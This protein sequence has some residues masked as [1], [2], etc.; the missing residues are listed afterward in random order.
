MT[1]TAARAI[2]PDAFLRLP[3]QKPALE[4]NPDGTISA[5]MSPNTDHAAL[6]MH[7][8]RL[9]LNHLDAVRQP[10]Y[11]YSELRTNLAG[12]SRLPDVAFY[13]QR[14]RT[15]T[16]KH[17]LVAADLSI[18]ILSPRD[19]VDE[20]RAKCRW[21]LEQGGQFALLV[22]PATPRRC[23]ELFGPDAA[24]GQF[25]DATRLPLEQLLPGLN[26]TPDA[27]FAILDTP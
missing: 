3:E 4:L 27:I 11:V 14:P 21:Y 17:A 25:Y 15:S 24:H 13:R 1:T 26:L 12:A 19:D 10:G 20:Q 5:K 2:S 23:V 8:G 16:R 7:I 6:Q 18:E 22:D 9:L